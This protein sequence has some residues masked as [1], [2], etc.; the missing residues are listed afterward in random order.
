M[1]TRWPRALAS[2]T[3]LPAKTSVRALAMMAVLAFS[4]LNLV[5]AQTY[6]VLYSFTGAGDGGNPGSV[7]ADQGGRL[8]G[9]TWFDG[10]F[11]W[12]TLFRLDPNGQFTVLHNFTGGDGLYANSQPT[13]HSGTIYGTTYEGGTPEGATSG[14]YGD[15]TIFK[16]DSTGKQTELYGFNAGLNSGGPPGPLTL[17]DDGNVYGVAGG[18]SQYAGGIVFKL[19]TAGNLTIIHGF[20]GQAD[21]S[22]PNAGLLRDV[23]GNIYGTTVLGG[24]SFYNMGCGVIFKL[25]PTG[26]ETVLYTFNGSDGCQPNSGLT[27]G[28]N[29][30]LYGTTTLGGDLSCGSVLGCGAVYKLDMTGKHTVL[31]RFTGSPDGDQPYNAPVLDNAGNL[32]GT[33][34]L[35]GQDCDVGCGTIFEL[36]TTGTETVLYRFTGGTDGGFPNAVLLDSAGNL[37]G[38]TSYG[39]VQSYGCPYNY[40]GCGVLFK[41]TP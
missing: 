8:Y 16:L 19:D 29:G 22:V 3:K 20:N 21:G 41:L 14:R 24:N 1:T 30:S 26:E 2:A 13:L 17:D 9:G 5:Q 38:S 34:A 4:S 18:G 23:A 31:H 6:T 25:T 12:G 28:K 39:G 7:I 10:S 27:L 37:Y 32:Y 11:D 40:P 35:G 36:D 15:G 33:T